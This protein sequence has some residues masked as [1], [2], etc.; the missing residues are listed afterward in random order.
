MRATVAKWENE[1]VGIVLDLAPNE[2][3]GL[4]RNLDA[5][6]RDETQHFHLSGDGNGQLGDMEIGVMSAG[7][8]HNLSMSSLAFAPGDEM[9]AWI[10]GEP[11]RIKGHVR[12][13]LTGALGVVGTVAG[14]QAAFHAFATFATNDYRHILVSGLWWSVA[15]MIAFHGVAVTARGRGTRVCAIVGWVACVAVLAEILSRLSTYIL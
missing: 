15:G 11:A 8:P 5:I 14:M 1:Q 10:S 7:Q 12:R 6:R 9:P 2:I 4:I 3:V 13:L